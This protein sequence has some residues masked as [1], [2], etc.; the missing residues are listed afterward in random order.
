ML[1]GNAD[2]HAMPNVALHKAG[3]RAG[4]QWDCQRKVVFQQIV[5]EHP[6]LTSPTWTVGAFPFVASARAIVV[7][8]KWALRA[9]ER[10]QQLNALFLYIF[11]CLKKKKKKLQYMAAFS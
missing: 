11:M 4:K 6:Q 9:G 2:C 1:C 7:F 10:K 5:R 3:R 8:I